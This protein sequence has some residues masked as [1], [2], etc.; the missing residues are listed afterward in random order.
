MQANRIRLFVA[1][2]LGALLLAGAARAQAQVTEGADPAIWQ[3]EATRGVAVHRSSNVGLPAEIE[4]FRRTRLA[5]VNADDAAANYEASDGNARTRLTVF[6]FRPG[7]LP[8]HSLRGSLTAFGAVSPTAFIWSTGPFD[9]P[10]AR[11][12]H[13]YKGVFK[14]G[15]GPDTVMDYLYFIPMGRWTVKV[16]ATVTGINDIRQE[17]RIDAFVRALAW[18]QILTANGECTGRACTAPAFERI[19]NHYMSAMLARLLLTRMTF[20]TA[21]EA[22]LPV[23]A[24]PSIG[25]MGPTEIRRADEG[26]VRYVATVRDLATYRLVRLPDPA[27]GLL[28][29]AFG[30]LSVNKPVYA[31]VVAMGSDRFM[32]FFF[33][34][35]PTP[36]AFGAAVDSLVMNEMPGMF[37][38]VAQAA[39]DM[40][41]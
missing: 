26:P 37:Y 21:A 20:D 41:D 10:G 24:R 18:D 25:I 27:V 32:P 2:L 5:A 14:T 11:P 8:E 22:R 7:S 17:Q 16:R 28:T 33:H 40:R 6:L 23:A 12:L 29:E 31:M 9:V 15:I 36:E 13:G 3:G 1:G 34:G 38:T 35:E 19:D 39:R 30:I 4:S